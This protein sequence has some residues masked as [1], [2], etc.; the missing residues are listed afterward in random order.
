MIWGYSAPDSRRIKIKTNVM[1]KK[2][3]GRPPKRYNKLTHSINL[4]LSEFD[5]QNLQLKA[6]EFRT[7]PTQ[8]ARDM[9]LNGSVK[10]PFTE[11]Q[12]GLMQAL[13]GVA[14]NLNQIA[15]H[16][17]EGLK[18]HKMDALVMIERIK[19]MMND[20]KKH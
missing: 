13:A 7:T 14:N 5:Y 8:F 18:S 20:S 19:K 10:S 11:E 15:K 9:V 1:R 6:K 17:N 4:K 2:N 16:L 3:V 12:M